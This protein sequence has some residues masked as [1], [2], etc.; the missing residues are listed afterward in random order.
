MTEPNRNQVFC[1]MRKEWVI[2]TPEELVRQKLVHHLIHDL[3]FPWSHIALEKSLRQMPHLTLADQL[4]LP[5]RRADLVCFAK[6][7]H[8]QFNLYPLLLVECK[9]VKLSERVVNQV[10]GYNHFV[11]AYF[12]A[13]VN[14]EEV[15][16][17]WYDEATKKYNF[18]NF[19]P[20]YEELVRFWS[21]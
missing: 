12:I 19:L 5:H 8:P 14:A 21:K 11:K 16:T 18:V 3:A 17:G 7:I 13:V 10:V 4:K 2:A 15:R 1:L 20:K 9:A 6:N